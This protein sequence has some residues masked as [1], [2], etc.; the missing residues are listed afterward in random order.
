ML[1]VGQND[2]LPVAKDALEGLKTGPSLI[3]GR[4]V[5]SNR[6]ACENESSAEMAA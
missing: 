4:G 5:Q 2:E 6:Y 1:D 3:S